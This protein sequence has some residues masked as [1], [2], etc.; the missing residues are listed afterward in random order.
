M[1]RG[2]VLA[3]NDVTRF[4]YR[5]RVQPGTAVRNKIFLFF[6]C[7]LFS[8]LSPIP[9]HPRSP[10]SAWC[11]AINTVTFSQPVY[12]H[13]HFRLFRLQADIGEGEMKRGDEEGEYNDERNLVPQGIA[14][15][16]K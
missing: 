4:T 10:D 13:C 14:I 8:T 6:L 9:G 15:N 12:P 3:L 7:S 5:M 11:I 1:T 2:I 16:V